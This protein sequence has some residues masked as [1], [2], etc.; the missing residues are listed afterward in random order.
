MRP[1]RVLVVD[2]D[3]SQRRLYCR[4]LESRG[5]EPIPAE[6]AAQAIALIQN[7]HP[8]LIVA[9]IAMPGMDG[10][11]L[12][13][14]LRLDR[15]SSK[16]PVLLMTGLAVPAS[17]LKEACVGLSADEIYIKGGD[18]THFAWLASKLLDIPATSPD[19]ATATEGNKSRRVR[20][21]IVHRRI[22]VDGTELPRLPAKRYDLLVQLLKN[23]EPQNP[24]NLLRSVWPES[25]N[26]KIVGVSILRLRRDL[27]EF[28][29]VRIETTARGYAAHLT[30]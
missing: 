27:C 24:N 19:S 2:D 25:E 29:I 17:L 26:I 4:F 14:A 16:I 7:E 22:W 15:R 18:L 30:E 28:P 11:Q 1:H 12:Y 8:Q 10:I 13:R 5:Y 23:N 3:Y 20:I 21:D 9:D 6:S